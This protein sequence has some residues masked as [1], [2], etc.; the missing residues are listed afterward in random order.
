MIDKKEGEA[1][2]AKQPDQAKQSPGAWD[3]KKAKVVHEWPAPAPLIACRFDPLGRFVLAA[4]ENNDIV[5]WSVPDGKLE[6]WKGHASWPRSLAVFPEGD[7][8]VSG[9]C[10][11][12]ILWWDCAPG[13]GKK[14]V[15]RVEAHRGWVRSV[16]VTPDGK[17]IASG[18]NDGMVKLWEADSGNP[19]AS[20]KGHQR[21]VYSVRFHPSGKWLLSGDLMGNVHQRELP[22]GKVVRTLKADALHSY[23]GGQRVDYGGV[24]DLAW[25]SDGK[26]LLAAGLSRATNPLGAVNQPTVVQFA[27]DSGKVVKNHV[28]D[29]KGVAWRVVGHRSSWF[30]VASGGSGGGYLLFWKP[31]EEKPA[32]QF[33]LPNTARG[34]D[35]SRDGHLFATA[36]YDKKIRV[37]RV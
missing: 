4:A 6:A 10:D 19:A 1:D 3:P 14:P 2:R 5:R 15:R 18:G 25:S 24:R 11:D 20:W 21:E 29:V 13:A 26:Q 37:T 27:W 33:K 16:D 31:S 22:S 23:N 17:W 34:M 7:R 8:A 12:A 36:H 30:V 9:G 35:V 28:S 32:V